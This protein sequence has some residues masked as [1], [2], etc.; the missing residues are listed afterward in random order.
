MDGFF[1]Q[2]LAFHFPQFGRGTGPN[3]CQGNIKF[4]ALV[5]QVLQRA[6]MNK[7]DGRLKAQLAKEILDSVKSCNGRFLRANFQEAT[8]CRSYVKVSDSVALD[9]IK[10]SFRHQLRVLG[11]APTQKERQLR[12]SQGVTGVGMLPPGVP[13]VLFGNCGSLQAAAA[14]Q[15]PLDLLSLASLASAGG[16]AS[17]GSAG[18]ALLNAYNL[19]PKETSSKDS[20]LARLTCASTNAAASQSLQG[21]PAAAMPSLDDSLVA[22]VNTL[23]AAKAEEAIRQASVAALRVPTASPPQIEASQ[24]QTNLNNA[25]L[26]Q[27]LSQRIGDS[28]Q[29]VAVNPQIALARALA[30][31]SQGSTP[32]PSVGTQSPNSISLLES[33]LNSGVG[34]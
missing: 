8:G 7:L 26:A 10:Q 18:N 14:M 4:R 30:M 19:L 29:S 3:E 21:L 6:D 1:F 17:Q 28:D 32:P 31:S 20:V 2:I 15:R 9:K 5:R 16:V 25:T 33:L 24:M 34:S 11:E 13:P 22:L 12:V 27:L 23:A